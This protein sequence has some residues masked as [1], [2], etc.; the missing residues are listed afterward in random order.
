MPASHRRRR[1]GAQRTWHLEHNP[2]FLWHEMLTRIWSPYETNPFNYNPLRSLLERI[3]FDG[4][5]HDP[6]RGA[7]IHLRDERSHRLAARVRE[8]GALGRRAA[9]LC[10]PAA[11][12]SGGRDRRRALLGRG[13]HRQSGAGA[14]LPEHGGERPDRGRHQPDR[15]RRSA[16]DRARH[17]RP[18]RRDQ[19]QLQLHG[20]GGGDRVLRGPDAVAAGGS[21]G[22]DAF[23]STASATRRSAR[24]AHRAR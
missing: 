24:S 13:L 6:Q 8:R 4:L 21:E 11:G 17:H 23:L 20:G 9:R 2:L 15:A 7:R 16:A 12:L 1:S 18:H 5:R 3:D 19:L 14:A 10:R 22:S